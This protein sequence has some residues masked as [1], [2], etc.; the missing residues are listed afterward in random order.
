MVSQQK[1]HEEGRE[2]IFI[3]DPRLRPRVDTQ[4]SIESR[5]EQEMHSHPHGFAARDFRLHG[6]AE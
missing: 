2:L 3:N 4:S 6:P 5:A 1:H